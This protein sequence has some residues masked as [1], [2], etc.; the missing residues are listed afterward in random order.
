MTDDTP[1]PTDPAPADVAPPPH[2][3]AAEPPPEPAA[4]AASD[5]PTAAEPPAAGPLPDDAEPA[6]EVS[7]TVEPG[8]S[9]PEPEPIA[10]A[11]LDASAEPEAAVEPEPAPAAEEEP[12]VADAGVA[13]LASAGVAE[14]AEPAEPTEPPPPESKKKWYV[15][16]V[17]SGREES[18]KAAI[19]RKVK[20]EGLEEFFGQIAI[21]F[22]EYNEKKKV[23]VTNKKTGEKETQERNVTKKR[24][25]FPGYLFAEVEYNDRIL[26]L[27]RET[28]GVGDFVGASLKRDPTPMTEHEVHSMLTG[29]PGK[30]DKQQKKVVHKIDFEKGDRVKVRDGAFA[31]SEGEVKEIIPAK[32]AADTPKVKVEVTIWG[33]PVPLE[34]DYWHVDKV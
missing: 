7:E 8:E 24:K 9:E 4:V 10:E 33:R 14:A 22:E 26:Y 13:A 21:P 23:R 34:L 2:A 3:L 15:V 5:H 1:A 19:E 17:Q 16:K 6:A 18:I 20:I 32:D 29:T 28:S 31:G 30:E 25:K 11:E 27:F 12:T